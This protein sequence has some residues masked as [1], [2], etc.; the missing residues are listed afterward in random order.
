[1]KKQVLGFMSL[2]QYVENTP[3][4]DSK[5]GELSTWSSTFSTSKGEYTDS[6]YPGYLLTTFSVI[7]AAT[8]VDTFLTP[9]EAGLYLKIAQATVTYAVNNAQPLDPNDFRD[10]IQAEFFDEIENLVFGE[11]VVSTRITMPAWI[12]YNQK[13]GDKNIVRIWFADENFAAEYPD[14]DLTI[15]P[16][17]PDLMIFTGGWQV[18][19]NKLAEWNNMRLID[20]VQAKKDLNPETYLRGFEFDF[21]NRINPTQK[22]PTTWYVLVYGEAGDDEDVIKDAIIDKLVKETGKDEQF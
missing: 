20:E 18:A 19:V 22:I 1:M 21:V 7:D 5:I 16:P 8:A 15:V 14:Y 9:V 4:Y 13:K 6:F 11:L 17:Y 3:G 2:A 10:Y 12:S